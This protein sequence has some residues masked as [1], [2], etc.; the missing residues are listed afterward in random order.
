MNKLLEQLDEKNIKSL[1]PGDHLLIRTDDD[2]KYYDFAVFITYDTETSEV[3]VLD[4]AINAES[5]N[6]ASYSMDRC[7]IFNP[8][9]LVNSDEY[10]DSFD[11]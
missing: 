1:N 3:I 10:L 8:S 5:I 11:R 4:C 9:L 7:L 2:L 6:R